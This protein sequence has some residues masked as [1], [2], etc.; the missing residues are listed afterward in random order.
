[1]GR[2]VF[3]ILPYTTRVVAQSASFDR[4]SVP[5][6]VSATA[7]D[8]RRRFVMSRSRDVI[9]LFGN[10]AIERK[11]CKECDTNALVVKGRLQCCGALVESKPTKFV[12]ESAP[13]QRRRTP[14][15]KDK[16]R[17]LRQQEDQC[18]YCGAR[19]G[20]IRSRH[21]DPFVIKINWD[22]QLPYAMSQNNYAYNFVAACQVCNGIKSDRIFQTIDEAKIYLTAKRRQKGFDF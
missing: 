18:F 11:Y 10:I 20:S 15:K 3:I 8:R 17:I 19:F 5:L 21:G 16:D 1:M 7:V 14:P 4:T 13:E 9:A 22:H 6:F 2:F 12:R